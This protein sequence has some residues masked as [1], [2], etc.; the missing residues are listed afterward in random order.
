M[1]AGLALSGQQGSGGDSDISGLNEGFSPYGRQYWLA[2]ELTTDEAVIAW[3]DG[4]LQDYHQQDWDASSE[5]VTAMYNRIFYQVSLCN[6]YLRET[7][8]NKVDGRPGVNAAL[9]SDIVKYRAEA[10]FLRALSYWHAL[11]MFRKPPFVTENDQVGSFIPPQASP[12][13]LFSYIESELKA[14]ESDLA[15]PRTNEYARADQ[16]AAWM[17]LAKLYLNAEVYACLLYTSRCV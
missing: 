6:E 13:Q 14:I 11:D 3:N 16:A 15:A 7:T 9:K 1:Y 10:R 2:Q 8:A 12:D 17:L 4:T 5:F